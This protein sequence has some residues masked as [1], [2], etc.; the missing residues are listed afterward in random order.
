MTIRRCVCAPT[1]C[2]DTHAPAYVCLRARLTGVCVD[3]VRAMLRLVV[4]VVV[5]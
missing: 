4:A 5:R 3:M 2:V 1:L